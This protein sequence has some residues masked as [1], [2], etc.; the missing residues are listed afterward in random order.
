M[1]RSIS[2]LV[3]LLC[4]AGITLAD[5]TEV[6]QGSVSGHWTQANSPYIVTGHL[7]LHAWDTLYVDAG[8]RV[9][10]DGPYWFEIYGLCEVNGTA[11]APVYFTADTLENTGWH[12][13]RPYPNCLFTARHA[14]FEN[15]ALG[16]DGIGAS[17]G[18]CLLEHCTIRYW[19][20]SGI[21]CTGPT[22]LTANNSVIHHGGITIFDSAR[23]FLNHC[24]LHDN[25]RFD[26][27]AVRM[28][29]G[30]L[31][32]R[33]TRFHDNQAAI[34]GAA[35]QSYQSEITL[36]HCI[37]DHNSSRGLGT[38]LHDRQ[39]AIVMRRC[40]VV[41]NSTDGGGAVFSGTGSEV[42]INSCIFSWNQPGPP[43]WEP[44]VTV[45]NCYIGSNLEFPP[46][47]IGN[48]LADPGFIEP[49]YQ[50]YRLSDTSPCIDAG[51]P[52]LPLD[53][54]GT[55]A[56]IGAF[57]YHQD[58]TEVITE[59]VSS[60]HSITLLQ[61]Y[62]NPFNA[63]TTLRFQLNKPAEV[64]LRIIDLLGREV[65][66]LLHQ[67]LSTG[68]YAVDWHARDAASGL[69]FALLDADGRQY[70]QKIALLK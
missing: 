16:E 61:A 7:W 56:D 37:F 45:Y 46:P 23:V 24:D 27:G 30:A 42:E 68:T 50:D 54:D 13:M 49:E 36:E 18:V 5:T 34:W 66:E 2:I 14:I 40:T 12:G 41:E 59:P 15:G 55:R 26:G 10:F 65:T 28:H 51:D 11:Q 29:E 52:D 57:Y 4:S 25:Y 38:V 32:A 22:H 63:R 6:V 64:S 33:Y 48:L 62:P 21:F 3:G 1:K 53:P 47:G 35:I 31:T 20:G 9:F 60:P 44:L 67:S 43:F 8:V 58:S 70:V 17:G 39:S 19:S 69:Y